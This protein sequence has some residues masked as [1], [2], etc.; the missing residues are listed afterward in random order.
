MILNLNAII[1]V[2]KWRNRQL[3]DMIELTSLLRHE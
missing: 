1:S 3:T 2:N